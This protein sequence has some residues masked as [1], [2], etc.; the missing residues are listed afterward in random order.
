MRLLSWTCCAVGTQWS[1]PADM[2]SAKPN[3]S[4]GGIG[5]WKVA[6]RRSGPAEELVFMGRLL[7]IRVLDH[8]IIG[9]NRYYSFADEGLIDRYAAAF[10]ARRGR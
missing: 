6:R 2:G 9:E 4:R 3:C 8:L 1:W 10:D 5:S 7:K